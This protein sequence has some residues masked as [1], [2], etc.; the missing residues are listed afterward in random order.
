MKTIFDTD[1]DVLIFSTKMM[2]LSNYPIRYL[3]W[4]VQGNFTDEGQAKCFGEVI[5]MFIGLYSLSLTISNSY[6]ANIGAKSLGK[7]LKRLINLH[8]L[9]ILAFKMI[10]KV[11]KYITQA[12]NDE[13]MNSIFTLP[14]LEK[15]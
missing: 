7:G 10:G 6:F 8:N 11:D 5:S 15:L 13:I 3:E 9:K 2:K 14:N 1:K 4:D 12:G